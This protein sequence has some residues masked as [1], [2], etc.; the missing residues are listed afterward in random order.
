[1]STSITP[2]TWFELADLAAQARAPDEPIGVLTTAAEAPAPA[3]PVAAV[4][5]LG[6]AH[7]CG[8]AARDHQ[9]VPA[10]DLARPVLR[11]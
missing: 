9:R 10:V 7:G 6:D 2:P 11:Q 8:D 5:A 1:M 3:D 4:G